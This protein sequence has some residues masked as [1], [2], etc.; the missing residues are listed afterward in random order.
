[1]RARRPF[2]SL[3]P[4]SGDKI[5][6]LQMVARDG[7]IG[8]EMSVIMAGAGAT[9][10]VIAKLVG[11]KMWKIFGVVQGGAH[12]LGFGPPLPRYCFKSL[13]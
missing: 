6:A 5:A 7:S 12:P 1:V 3:A 2:E 8:W 13:K 11:A 10:T 4:E 9:N